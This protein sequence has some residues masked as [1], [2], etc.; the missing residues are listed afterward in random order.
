MF[1]VFW[2]DV[3]IHSVS[4]LNCF[5]SLQN[6]MDLHVFFSCMK[7]FTKWPWGYW[8]LVIFLIGWKLWCQPSSTVHQLS[9]AQGKRGGS[10][11]CRGQFSDARP[12]PE[13]GFLGS[14]TITPSIASTGKQCW[15]SIWSSICGYRNA[16][17]WIQAESVRFSEISQPTDLSIG[18]KNC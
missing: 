14:C 3:A 11:C 17:S 18:L 10:K 15:T 4:I 6:S 1:F 16:V 12:L 9:E 8:S 13:I 7:L 5:F 2:K